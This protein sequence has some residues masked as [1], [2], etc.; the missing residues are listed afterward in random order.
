MGGDDAANNLASALKRDGIEIKGVLSTSAS[1]LKGKIKQKEDKELIGDANIILSLTCD[2]GSQCASSVFG[3]EALNPFVT[4]GPG[5]V[6]EDRS[7]FVSSHE[8]N[9]K[10]SNEASKRGLQISPYV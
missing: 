5:F 2:I 9:E 8:G 6:D 3:I 7:L 1:C 4:L 10:L